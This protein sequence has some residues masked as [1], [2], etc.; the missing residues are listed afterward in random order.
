MDL[1]KAQ[2]LRSL[3]TWYKSHFP[4]FCVF[5]V[6]FFVFTPGLM[7][8]DSKGLYAQAVAHKY[9]DIQAPL[10]AYLWH[11]LDL[12]YPGPLLMFVMNLF[13]LGGT[14]YILSHKLFVKEKN[15]W[16]HYYCILIP[17]IPHIVSYLG[18]VW[19]DLVFTFSY[20]VLAAYLSYLTIQKRQF[21]KLGVVGFFLLLIY[22]T[23]VKY[24]AQFILPIILLWFFMVETRF[25]LKRS[26][27]GMIPAVVAVLGL[28]MVLERA[29]IDEKTGTQNFGQHK[30]IYDLAGIS[31][32][33]G[34]IVVP[35][36]LHKRA[37]TLADL[38]KK[39]TLA[40]EPLVV[41]SDSPLRA[42][43]TETELK[44]LRSAWLKEMRTRPAAYLRHRL[45]IWTRGIL[46]GVP[47]QKWVDQRLGKNN[48]VST[49]LVPLGTL[50]RYVFLLPFQILFFVLGIWG[51]RRQRPR[52]YAQSL[53]FL[54][55]MGVTL[56]GVLFFFSLAAVPRYIYFTNFMSMLSVPFAGHLYFL[57]KNK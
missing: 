52:P 19:K 53:L 47:G 46:L 42:A 22:G 30:M 35:Q 13:M 14:V 44:L 29:V 9:N 8:P 28:I 41:E 15:P 6:V 2:I 27:L 43:Q 36:M 24:Q 54:S 33:S 50:M 48:F 18:F 57:W 21:S 20:G 5:L 1:S 45:H 34:Q 55:A 32:F 39:Y 4:F 3:G 38:E 17:F 31:L 23:S 40:W 37:L 49:H 26:L 10:M 7:S 25:C 12:I 11:Y 56:L 16:L 51:L